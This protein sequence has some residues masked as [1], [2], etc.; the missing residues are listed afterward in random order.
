MQAS[1]LDLRPS[2]RT[3]V[4]GDQ[5][6][7]SDHWS[8]E[9][10]ASLVQRFFSWYRKAVFAR[11]VAHFVGRYFPERGV[12]IEAGC[13]TSE[14]SIRINKR[15]GAC[16]LVALDLIIPVLEQ[17]NPVMDVRIGGDIFRLPFADDSVDGIWNVGVMEH[18]THEQI[19]AILQ[20]LRRVLRPGARV[21]L[22]WPGS[23]S[24]PQ[25]MLE[26]VAWFI[27][28]RRRE[29]PFRFHPAEISRL[30]S[31][32]QGREVLARNGLE[33]VTIDPGP[34]SLMAFKTVVGQKPGGTRAG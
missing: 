9:K 13:G 34:R 18:F 10:Q 33:T 14:T 21:I 19:D 27:N 3:A 2:G 28:L 12:F 25:K 1:V 24:I 15:G 6:A 31:S 8:D 23:D 29:Q 7:W 11:T 32:R 22:L 17:C 5:D 20:E 16:T 4:Q 26:V 30:R